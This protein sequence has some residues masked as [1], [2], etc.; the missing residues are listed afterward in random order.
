MPVDVSNL[1]IPKNITLAD[2]T[3]Y[4]PSSPVVNPAIS[5]VGNKAPPS[6]LDV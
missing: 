3:I 4:K 2:P 6:P 1:N 5:R